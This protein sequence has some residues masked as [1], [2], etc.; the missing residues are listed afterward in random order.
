MVPDGFQLFFLPESDFYLLSSNFQFLTSGFSLLPSASVLIISAGWC[1]IGVKGVDGV[2]AVVQRVLGARVSVGGEA[3][4]E[5]A[6]GFLVL[7]GVG[8]GDG[9]AECRRLAAKIA[10]LRI[11]ADENGKTNLA[12]GDV[13]GEVLA[14]S[15]FTLFADCTHGNRPSFLDAAPPE[16]A[17][18]LY[19]RFCDELGALGFVPQKGIFGADMKIEMT[20]DGPFTVLMDTE[21]GL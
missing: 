8:K 6:R 12:L 16:S 4:G 7:L 10:K 18:A 17:N 20:A 13:G 21:D 11:F 14:V 1:I 3:V 9:E 15:Q 5:I 2:R 19:E